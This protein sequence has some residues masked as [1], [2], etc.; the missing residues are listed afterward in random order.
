MY[1]QLFYLSEE[2]NS[3]PQTERLLIDDS[4]EGL[5]TIPLECEG[6]NAYWEYS[7]LSER[8]F[9]LFGGNSIVDFNSNI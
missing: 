5:L 1:A 2:G 6:N 4:L 8:E 9:S 3:Y 7:H